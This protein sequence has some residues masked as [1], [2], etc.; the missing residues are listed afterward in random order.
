MK[1]KFSETLDFGVNVVGKRQADQA[2]LVVGHPMTDYRRVDTVLQ[3][4]GMLPAQTTQQLG[5]KPIEISANILKRAGVVPDFSVKIGQLAPSSIWQILALDL[6]IGNSDNGF[7]GW[8]DPQSIYL[9]DYWHA[10]DPAIHFIFVYD[11]L[12]HVLVRATGGRELKPEDIAQLANEWVCFYAA[13]THFYHRHRDRCLLVH[14]E[15]AC[16]DPEGFDKVLASHLQRPLE[17]SATNAV[18]SMALDLIEATLASSLVQEQYNWRCAYEELQSQADFPRVMAQ[19]NYALAA[20]NNFSNLKM[21]IRQQP[22]AF[23]GEESRLTEI[24]SEQQQENELLLSQ[25]HQAQEELERYYLQS[26]QLKQSTSRPEAKRE[27]EKPSRRNYCA[28]DRVKQMLSYRLGAIIIGRADSISGWI[29]M[30]SALLREARQ[31]EADKQARGETKLP[32]LSSYADASEA[33]RV[34]RHLSFRLGSTL[35]A[36]YKSPLGWIKLP[37]LMRQQLTEFKRDRASQSS[38]R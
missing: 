31:F 25:L 27:Q 33:E 12:E 26:Q 6:L 9:L 10:A 15:Q 28:A 32:P 14:A 4:V 24:H 23:F 36:N 34:K 30:P 2:V 1:N 3:G 20:W 38:S 19:S 21:N 11:S 8:S 35:L 29:G 7:W 13:V 22:E 16:L 37:W 17:R 18:V 5:L